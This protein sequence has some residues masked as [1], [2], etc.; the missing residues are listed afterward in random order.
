MEQ[1]PNI[2]DLTCRGCGAT[3]KPE[4]HEGVKVTKLEGGGLMFTQNDE[5]HTFKCPHCGKSFATWKPG[6]KTLSGWGGGNQVS[7]R[8]GGSVNGGNIIIGG[9]NNVVVGGQKQ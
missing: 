3:M 2:I 6:P 4:P 5:P 1:Q 9:N 8:I 7:I